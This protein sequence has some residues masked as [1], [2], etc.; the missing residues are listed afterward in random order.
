MK[1]R[2]AVLGST[3]SI[4][5]ST[6]SVISAMRDHFEIS[7]LTSNQN[8][9]LFNKQLAEWAPALAAVQDESAFKRIKSGS[10]P[11]KTKILS[12][13]EGIREIASSPETDIVICA[14]SGSASLMPLLSAIEAGK[15]IGLASKEPIVMTGRL[16][17]EAARKTGARIIPVDSEPNAISQC[18]GQSGSIDE[19]KSFI[20][21]ASGGPFRNLSRKAI[22]AATPKMALSHP[23][24]DMGAKISV[25]SSTMMNKGL[26][27]IEAHNLFGLPYDKIKVIIHPEAKIHSMVEFVDGNIMSVMSRTDMRVPIQ[28]ALTYPRRAPSS[29][30]PLDLTEGGRL[31]FKKPDLKK[32]PGLAYCFEAGR[33][34]GTL[35]AALNAANE[36]AVESFL[37]GKIRL[38][39]ISQIC[40]KTMDEHQTEKIS[41]IEHVLDVDKKARIS[42]ME[43]VKKWL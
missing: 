30:E 6:L 24:W 13:I 21:T 34:G 3:G 28:Y 12:G 4:G 9:S 14:I 38:G 27:V 7:G 10:R 43:M 36:V 23:A 19:V 25:D 8:F 33:A 11:G 5:R 31:T 18:L 32:F 35:P 17:I 42:A 22:D 2:V 40:R 20:I 26:E 15:V 41:G 29:L 1:K 16:L 39:R 37:K